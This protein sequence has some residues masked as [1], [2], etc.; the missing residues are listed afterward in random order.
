MLSFPLAAF[1]TSLLICQWFYCCCYACAFFLFSFL[2]S[3]SLV[4]H[5]FFSLSVCVFFLKFLILLNDVLSVAVYLVCR[6]S[7]FF[8]L[9]LFYVVVVV[10]I[11]PSCNY[12]YVIALTVSLSFYQIDVTAILLNA[13]HRSLSLVFVLLY[14]VHFFFFC[15]HTHI[16]CDS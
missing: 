10:G 16:L 7:M 11:F 8:F 12:D 4:Y 2:F 1:V 9:F 15:K 5:V 14:V 3:S 6:D 13:G